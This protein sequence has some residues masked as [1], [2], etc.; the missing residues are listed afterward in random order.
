MASVG[1]PR[2]GSRMRGVEEDRVLLAVALLAG[3]LRDKSRI[4]IPVREVDVCL[5]PTF[6]GI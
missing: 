1:R 5:A 2:D 6:I 3:A 4:K